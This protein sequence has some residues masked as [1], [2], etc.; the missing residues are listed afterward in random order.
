MPHPDETG[1]C[2]HC[3]QPVLWTVTIPNNARQAVNPEPDP[4]GNTCVY[5][6]EAGRLRSRQLTTERPAPEHAEQLYMPHA[7][8]CP[9][10][11]PRRRQTRPRP[12][13]RAALP[14]QRRLP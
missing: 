4:A 5:R 11:A 13:P 14:Y 2:D 12:R 7:A 9:R 3:L 10:P 6:D 1:R 8:T